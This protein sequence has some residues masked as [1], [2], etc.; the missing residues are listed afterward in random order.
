M[1]LVETLVHAGCTRVIASRGAGAK[2]ERSGREEV[3]VGGADSRI[4]VIADK[5]QDAT[6]RFDLDEKGAPRWPKVKTPLK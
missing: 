6:Y 1:Q 3:Y 5:P 4:F 2:L